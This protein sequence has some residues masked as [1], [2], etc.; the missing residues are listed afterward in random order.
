MSAIASMQVPLL[1]FA[2][3]TDLISSTT[4]FLTEAFIFTINR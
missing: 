4:P 1:Q 3:Q 2:F